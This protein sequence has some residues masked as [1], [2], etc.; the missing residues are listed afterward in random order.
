MLAQFA[1]T[2]FVALLALAGRAADSRLQSEEVPWIEGEID[3][4]PRD[5]HAL[6]GKVESDS[7]IDFTGLRVE[8]TYELP[9][10]REEHSEPIAPDGSF[11]IRGL[12]SR[13]CLMRV[14]GEA[15]LGSGWRRI[16]LPEDEGREHVFL[17][18]PMA[19]LAGTVTDPEGRPIEGARVYAKPNSIDLPDRTTHTSEQGEFSFHVAPGGTTLLVSAMDFSLVSLPFE[20]TPGEHIEGLEVTLLTGSKIQGRIVN[21]DGSGNAEGRVLLRSVDRPGVQGEIGPDEEGYFVFTGIDAGRW[22]ML[23]LEKGDTPFTASDRLRFQVPDGELVTVELRAGRFGAHQARGTLT[24]GGRGVELAEIEA[25]TLD[26][27]ARVYGPGFSDEEGG[28]L[29]FAPPGEYEIRVRTDAGMDYRFRRTVSE[30]GVIPPIE[31]P[32]GAVHG[33]VLNPDGSPAETMDVFLEG[34]FASGLPSGQLFVDDDGRFAFEELP[35]GTYR[36]RAGGYEWFDP[37]WEELGWGMVVDTVEVQG[38]APTEDVVLRM[39]PEGRLDGRVVSPSGE[40]VVGALLEIWA[41]DRLPMR[42]LDFESDTD[43]TFVT[44]MLPSGDQ[45][46]VSAFS[47]QLVSPAPVPFQLKVDEPVELDLELVPGGYVEVALVDTA[48]NPVPGWM[49]LKDAQGFVY[50]DLDRFWMIDIDLFS[51][52]AGMPRDKSEHRLGPLPPGRFTVEA[53]S[54]AGTTASKEVEVRA[55]ETTRVRIGF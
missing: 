22:E 25:E 21:A 2:S 36:I 26:P 47:G 29:L 8:V 3:I 18:K 48:G 35:P 31:L 14:A 38:D 46:F 24:R 49:R 15:F 41:H 51:P 5:E 34:D 20:L 39:R 19:H 16:A 12:P 1:L 33:I 7:L 43:G 32:S 54:T 37:E 28:F 10:G 40:P 23:L 13:I 6:R 4:A 17:V 52:E 27:I 9:S 53:R 11:E 45:L 42:F 44:D 55:G 50:E 30:D